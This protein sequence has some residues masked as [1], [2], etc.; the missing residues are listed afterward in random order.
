[1][2]LFD[3]LKPKKPRTAW[4]V[5]Q[6]NPLFQQ[7]KALFDAMSKVCEAGCDTD[8]LP[9]ALGEFGLEPTNPIPTK[10]IFG[11]TYYL[12]LLRAQD[13]AKVLYERRGSRSSEVTQ[14]PIDIYEIKHPDGRLLATLY[15]SPYQRRNSQKAPQGSFRQK[16]MPG[17]AATHYPLRDVYTR[18]GNVRAVVHIQ[19]PA[20]RPTMNSYAN[21]KLWMCAQSFADFKRAFEGQLDI[22]FEYKRHAIAG[23]KPNEFPF[24]LG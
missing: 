2:G 12:S 8:E 24:R 19:Q 4:D 9:N 1:M 23:G 16:D 17:V 7:Q 15:F 11:S 10:T 14:M 3:F 13:G 22:V 20:D 18:T 6:E 21:P 5:L